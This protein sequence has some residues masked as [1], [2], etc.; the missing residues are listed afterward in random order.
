MSCTSHDWKGY[1]LG[2]LP[3]EERR[4]AEEHLGSCPACR[5]ELE[6]LRLTC[7]A[8]NTLEEE[9]VPQRI[10][11][12]SD[13]V[14]EPRW[15]QRSPQWAMLAAGVLAAAIVVH[16]FVYRPVQ[17]SGPGT[18]M[19]VVQARI[20]SEVARRVTVSEQKQQTMLREAVAAVEKRSEFDRRAD[21]VKVEETLEYLQKRMAVMV[22]ASNER[23][24]A[25]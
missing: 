6:R 14:F 18:D 8:L 25:R 20:E 23:G 2:E 3:D 1:F 21:Q 11:F 4:R 13:R 22:L 15:W 16:A 9:P 12:V 7:A 10:A 24:G 17:Q 19:A 5:E